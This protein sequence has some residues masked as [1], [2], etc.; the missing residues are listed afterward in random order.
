MI[1]IKK[2]S[3]PADIFT[4]SMADISFLLI[5][6]FMLTSV[7]SATRGMDFA[8]PEEE[9]Q[10][11]EIKREDSIDVHVSRGAAETGVVAV[12]Q[13]QMPL[14]GMI[15]YIREKLEQNPDKPI[16]LRTDPEATYGDMVE[17]FDELRNAQEQAKA[18]D[19]PLATMNISIPTQREIQ[20]VWAQFG[21]Q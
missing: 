21:I 1:N 11:T 20:N 18:D 6:Y 13:E 3:V 10:T 12:D 19:G 9:Q 15:A 7:F 2:R 16:I 4:G 17:V 8:L 14:E 5:I